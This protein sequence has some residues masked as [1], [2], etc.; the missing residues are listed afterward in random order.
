MNAEN[1]E[2][3]KDLLYIRAPPPCWT[4]QMWV[5]GCILWGSH[6]VLSEDQRPARTLVA[7]AATASKHVRT[8]R[9]PPH[10]LLSLALAGPSFV[11]MLHASFTTTHSDTTLIHLLLIW[12]PWACGGL[13]K[14]YLT[15]VVL[16][17]MNYI[18]DVVRH[19][20]GLLLSFL[21]CSRTD[22]N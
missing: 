21:Q 14:N 11:I 17:S 9:P 10:G 19:S 12:F 2:I 6:L 18:L 15:A 5:F 13:L 20:C 7:P 8:N 1:H 16:K 3:P 4:V 22:L